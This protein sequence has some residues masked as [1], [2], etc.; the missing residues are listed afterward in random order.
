MVIS[1]YILIGY[2]L[3]LNTYLVLEFWK[4]Y[5]WIPEFQFV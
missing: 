4:L 3:G 1:Q 2:N 5:F